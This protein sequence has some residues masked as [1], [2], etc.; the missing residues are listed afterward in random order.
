M[1]EIAI[2]SEIAGTVWKLE[3]SVGDSV[4]EEDSLMILESMKMEIPVL[5]PDA[6]KVVAIHVAEG[7]AVREG[8]ALA[9]LELE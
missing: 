2:E 6:G 8:Q 3:M 1:A 7:D 9:T 5:A 4:E